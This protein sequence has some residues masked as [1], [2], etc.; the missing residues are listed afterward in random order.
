MVFYSLVSMSGEQLMKTTSIGKGRRA[1][2]KQS[3]AFGALSAITRGS[4][5]AAPAT[6]DDRTYWVQ[7]LTQVSE[8][9][10]R[11][12]S[13]RRLKLE[14]PVEAPHGNVAERQQ[15]TYLEAMGRLLSGIAPWL[16][17]GPRDGSE[18]AL[19]SR[20]AERSRAAIAA[21]TEPASP[22]SMNFNQGSQPVVDAAFLALAILRAPTE[23]WKKLDSS[24][25]K[26]VITALEATRVIQPGY[27]NWLLFSAIIEA[28]LSF[29]G[30]WWDPMRV[31]FAI[32][33]L[34]SWYK[35]DGWYGDG[36]WLH[37]DYYNSFVI[38]P[39]LLMIL[40]TVGHSS[41]A[42]QSSR[43]PMLLRA[44]RYAVIQERLISPEA[45]FPAIGRSLCYRFGAFH[46]L[47]DMSLR[48]ALPQDISPQQVR[49][50]LTAVMRRMMDAPGTFDQRGW[51]TVGFYGHQP[52]I[53]EGYISTGSCYLCSAAWLPL[54]LPA[55]DPFW[56]APAAPWT[57]KKIWSGEPVGPDH[58]LTDA[59]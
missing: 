47:A 36:P 29:M 24:T 2:L 51:L 42:W 35:G 27:S 58:A 43:A 7:V 10:L 25:Q 54:G 19:R 40:D 39:M 17:S 13:E 18:G 56:S 57:Q 20:Y 14:M 37:W 38:H 16:E 32:R 59:K 53:G 26:H 6:G 30:V 45:T 11:A 8:P 21:G 55:E 28:A 44:G 3:A 33:T 46:L 4:G 34:D 23:L 12:L 15:F 1:F 50:A 5:S 41:A 31:D 52:S 48:R 22:D 49:S 9:V